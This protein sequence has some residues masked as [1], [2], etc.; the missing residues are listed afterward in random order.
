MWLA[1]IANDGIDVGTANKAIGI[2]NVMLKD[3]AKSLRLPIRPIF[4]EMRIRGEKKRQRPAFTREWVQTRILAEGALDGLNA[5]A[6]AIV[7][8]CADT[9]M[10]PVEV[11]NLD[12]T[13]IHLEAVVP[14]VTVRPVGRKLK[15]DQS[16][17]DIPLVGA[18]L[19]AMKR[20]PRGFKRYHDKGDSLSAVV[21]KYLSEHKL[22]P[23]PEHSNYSFRHCFEDR[24][25]AVEAPEK[26]IAALMGHKY[27]RP[28]YGAGPSL[29]QKREW[30][31]KIAFTPP[32]QFGTP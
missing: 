7:W 25:T 2:L 17:R 18:A 27:S 31:Q 10:R 32:A 8:I 14:H 4:A 12:V 15:T 30:L 28:K 29:E 20:F 6:R 19:A 22:L 11:A 5:E 21:N 24:L 3:V 1:R 23:T 26:L 13:S 9:G 16:E